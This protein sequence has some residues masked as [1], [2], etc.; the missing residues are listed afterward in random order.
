[1]FGDMIADMECNKKLSSRITELEGE[2]SILYLFLCHKLISK[3]LK[4]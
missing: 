1:M 4:L 2:N 3:C